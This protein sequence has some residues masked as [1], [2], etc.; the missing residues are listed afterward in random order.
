MALRFPPGRSVEEPVQFAG[1]RLDV[2]CGKG[3]ATR[4]PTE[5]GAYFFVL[6]GTGYQK[7]HPLCAVDDGSGDADA[8]LPALGVGSHRGGVF[9]LEQLQVVGKNGGG[10][11]VVAHPEKDEVEGRVPIYLLGVLPDYL[12]VTHGFL[13]GVGFAVDAVN[14][15]GGDRHVVE[16][17]RPGDAVIAVGVVGRDAALVAPEE[18]DGRPVDL[19]AVGGCPQLEQQLR[20][21]AARKGHRE[22]GF[23]R[24]LLQEIAG[25]IFGYRRGIFTEVNVSSHS[26]TDQWKEKT[27][28]CEVARR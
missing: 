27:K 1:C 5:N 6:T 18:V 2:G 7:S 26:K 3:L 21:T 14:L 19:V 10:M 17:E 9:V 20:G 11:P 25:K 8:Q 23:S 4:F 28:L 16:Q 15:A 24:Q 12:G 13:G 22:V